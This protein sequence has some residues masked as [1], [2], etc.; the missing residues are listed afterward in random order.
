MPSTKKRSEYAAPTIIAS[1]EPFREIIERFGVL[2]RHQGEVSRTLDVSGVTVSAIEEGRFLAGDPLTTWVDPVHYLQ[3]FRQSAARLWPVMNAI[4]PSL[5]DGL[6]LLG[7]KLGLD[8]AWGTLVLRAVV[9][10]ETEALERGAKEAHVSSDF[11]LTA[12]SAVWS[13]VAMAVRP[14]LLGHV[15]AELW[16]K[17]YCPVC[18]SDPDLG[19]LENHPDPSEFLVSKSG[20]IWHH[21]PVCTHRWRFVRM[22]CPGCGNQDHDS[23]TRFTS[24]ESPREHIY[25]CEKCRQYLPCLDLVEHSGRIEHDLAALNLVHLDAVAQNRGYSPL[26][27]APWTALGLGQEHARA[28]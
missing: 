27:P 20:E 28:S 15:P 22:V 25:A 16:R 21:C 18:G 10:G 6:N 13:P 19:M 4:F 14:A 8:D 1:H 17:P 24:P 2:I 9:L 7:E 11:L 23:L 12:L 3:P 26:S 5:G